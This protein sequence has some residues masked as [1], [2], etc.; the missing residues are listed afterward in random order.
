MTAQQVYD[1][2]VAY[3]NQHRYAFINWYVGIATDARNRL[4]VDHS[5]SEHDGAWIYRTASS[6]TAARNVEQ[7]LLKLGCKGGGGGGSISTTQVYAYLITNQTV[8]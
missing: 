6:D 7:A 5:V 1:D 8:E 4:F 3:M 2:I